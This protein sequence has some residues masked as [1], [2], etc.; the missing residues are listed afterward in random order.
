MAGSYQ[1]HGRGGRSQLQL[2]WND[3][4]REERVVE[5]PQLWIYG[6]HQDPVWAPAGP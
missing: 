3:D 2:F 4:K 6:H 5:M 1:R